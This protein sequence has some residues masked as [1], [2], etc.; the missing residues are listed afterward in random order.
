MSDKKTI[1][2]VDDE[3]DIRII[4]HAFLDSEG[5]NILEAP[6]GPAGLKTAQNQKVDMILLDI[7][8]PGMDG[9][10]TLDNLR[11]NSVTQDIP[12]IMLTGLDEK[13]KIRNALSKG[14]T[15]Y[16]TKPFDNMDLASKIRTVLSGQMI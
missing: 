7:M 10:Q 13:D 11:S 8:M 4:L 15:Y 2:I 5:Y 9:F 16:V 12:V 3:E 1:L 14:V 6:D